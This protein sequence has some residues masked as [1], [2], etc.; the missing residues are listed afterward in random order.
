MQVLVAAGGRTA[1]QGREVGLLLTLITDFSGWGAQQTAPCVK[2][3]DPSP[4][5]FTA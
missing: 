2:L 4:R 3:N 5:P 1:Q